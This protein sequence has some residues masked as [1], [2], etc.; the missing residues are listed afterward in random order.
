M[1]YFEDKNLSLTP[2]LGK[3]EHFAWVSIK[4]FVHADT[5]YRLLIDK[6]RKEST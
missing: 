6:Q 1:K 5:K 3:R 2:G 4:M